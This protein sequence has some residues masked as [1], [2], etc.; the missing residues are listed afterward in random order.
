MSPNNALNKDAARETPR[1]LARTLGTSEVYMSGGK[2]HGENREY[3]VKCRDVLVFRDSTLVPWV[4]D[5]ID[6]QFD[7]PDTKWS[8]DVALRRTTGGE[9]IVAECRRTASAMKQEDVA[10]FA[11][12]VELLR[13]T[14]GLDVAG[15]FM[16]KTGHQVG[17]V[18]VGRY[19]GIDLAILSEDAA[20]PGFN[21]TFLR[22]DAERE[23]KMRD[24]VMHVPTG[25][26]SLT[27]FA[28]TLTHG[29]ASGESES[30]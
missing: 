27:G 13:K 12:K 16:T 10:A 24:I 26:L 9:L 14:L 19:N 28:A 23:A 4:D 18:R 15:V 6:I 1:L 5:G 22:Y 7:L 30:R 11:Y 29:K 3:Q 2:A 17:A 8:V 20:P 25:H 21:I